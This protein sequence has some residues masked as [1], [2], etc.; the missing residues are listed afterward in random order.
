MGGVR[1]LYSGDEKCEQGFRGKPEGTR[2]FGRQML[3]GEY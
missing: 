3:M 2:P 1:G